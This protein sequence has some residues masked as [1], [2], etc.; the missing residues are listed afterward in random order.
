MDPVSS[1]ASIIAIVQAAGMLFQVAKAFHE[2]FISK[3]IPQRAQDSSARVASIEEFILQIQLFK[4][5]K[6]IY[7]AASGA[8][9]DGV[10]VRCEEQLQRLQKKMGKLGLPANASGFRKFVVA[11]KQKVNE[12][13]FAQIDAAIT[14]LLQQLTLYISM[15]Q[16]QLTLQG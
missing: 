6:T 7:P 10:L 4:A 13:E 2:T 15:A 11:I 1:A 14:I 9:I 3:E 8:N 5:V 12:T 16:L